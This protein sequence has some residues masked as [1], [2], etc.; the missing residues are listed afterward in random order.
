MRDHA[1]QAVILIKNDPIGPGRTAIVDVAGGHDRV[2]E[3]LAGHGEVEVLVVLVL[4]RVATDF[5]VGCV[6]LPAGVL[7]FGDLGGRVAV[8]AAGVGAGAGGFGEGGGQ[9]QRGDQ[10]EGEEL[11]LLVSVDRGYRLQ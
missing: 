9:G 11:L 2:L 1:G 6:Q 8:A 3:V 4:V 10:E 7:G 5:L